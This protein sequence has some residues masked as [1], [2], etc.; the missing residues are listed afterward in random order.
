MVNDFSYYDR[1]NKLNKLDLSIGTNWKTTNIDNDILNTIFSEI[2]NGDNLI[3]ES[4]LALLYRLL[5][6]ADNSITN[7]KNDHIVDNKE[8]ANRN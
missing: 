3:Q 5:D 7:S 4:E 8:P 6:I 1:N 2:D